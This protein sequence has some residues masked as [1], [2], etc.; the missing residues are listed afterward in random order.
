MDVA[1]LQS[2][3]DSWEL[4]HA[5]P[6][7]TLRSDKD[8]LRAVVS[9]I[10]SKWCGFRIYAVGNYDAVA[11]TDRERGISTQLFSDENATVRAL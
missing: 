10:L 4:I 5:M 7:L 8:D 6:L 11:A 9:N 2:R 3:C 1:A